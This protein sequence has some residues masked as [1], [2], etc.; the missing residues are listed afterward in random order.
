MCSYSAMK[1]D[2]LKVLQQEAQAVMSAA[3]AA[4][5]AAAVSHAEASTAAEPSE[6]SVLPSFVDLDPTS[7]QKGTSSLCSAV[8]LAIQAVHCPSNGMQAPAWFV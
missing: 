6:A 7:Q 2:L 5:R 1:R 3:A 8:Q 4:P